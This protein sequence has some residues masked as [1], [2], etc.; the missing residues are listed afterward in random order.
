MVNKV[1]SYADHLVSYIYIKSLL[2]VVALTMHLE[3]ILELC[4]RLKVSNCPWKLERS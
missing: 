1:A 2:P 3:L 4:A